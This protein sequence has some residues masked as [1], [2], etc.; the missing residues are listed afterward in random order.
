MAITNILKFWRALFQEEHLQCI[1]DWKI[2]THF[3]THKV[4][5]SIST[6]EQAG[7]N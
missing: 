5:F 3:K 4:H 7:S 6:S 1:L 2:K